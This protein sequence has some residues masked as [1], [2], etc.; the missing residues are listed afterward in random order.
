MVIKV[1]AG[2]LVE[3]STAL[4]QPGKKRYRTGEISRP[5][6]GWEPVP[7]KPDPARTAKEE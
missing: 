2:L 4:S 5:G 6:P 1:P 7:D 3:T